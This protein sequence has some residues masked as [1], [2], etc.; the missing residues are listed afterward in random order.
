MREAP[1]CLE[2]KGAHS[3]VLE[4]GLEHLRCLNEETDINKMLEGIE[5]GR[6]C[7]RKLTL[8]VLPLE[9]LAREDSFF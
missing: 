9:P 3:L 4:T 6:F 5:R 7:Q 8:E 2:V 1:R